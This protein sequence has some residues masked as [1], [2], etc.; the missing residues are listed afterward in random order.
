MKNKIKNIKYG[1]L[2]IVVSLMVSCNEN[3]FLKEV[4]S[5][6]YSPE[7]SYVNMINFESSLTDLYAKVR[8][9][10]YSGDEYLNTYNLLGTDII[11][12]ARGTDD[13]L[14]NYATGVIPTNWT[15]FQF[16][17]DWYKIIS[18]A[19]TMLARLD[20]SKLTDVQKVKVE[21]EAKF[22]RGFAYR[23]L[24]YLYGGVPLILEE[25]AVPKADFTRASKTDVLNQ[26]VSDLT[27]AASGLPTID[28]V[29]DGKVSNVVASHYLAETLIALGRYDEAIA[30]A[31]VTINDGNTALMTTRFGSRA[32]QNPYDALLKFTK[33]GDPFWDLFQVGNQNRKSG[34]KEA[35]W[36]IQM[37]VDIPGGLIESTTSGPNRWER[38]CNPAGWLTMNDP[39]GKQGMT[40]KPYSD[41]N[42]GGRGISFIK[43]TDFFLKD[44]WVSDFNNDI[45]NAPHNIVRDLVYN[46][47]ASAY[48]GKSAVLPNGTLNSSTWTN[49]KW[50]WYPYP[51]KNTTPGQHPDAVYENKELGTLKASASSTYRD[52]YMLR[53]AETYLLRAE[54]YLAKGD[55]GNAA[56]DINVVRARAKANP[57]ADVNVTI[58]YIL[59]ERA[60]ELVYEEQRRL[61][62][63]RT[64]KLVERVRLHNPQNA[65][66]IKDFNALFPIPSA[67][68]EANKDV[69]LEQNPGY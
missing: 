57:I 63:S 59:D 41:Y 39:A 60:R 17:R 10:H 21:A 52:M 15:I 34:N 53:L 66:N 51:S 35:L 22:F 62:L 44:L 3:D 58:D 33:P 5:D 69:V 27:A 56:I 67:E 65:G 61:T 31:S 25:V 19:N 68:I 38:N 50:R 49:Q 7:N 14:G 47:P 32:T 18:N 40:T 16:W 9:I 1:L 43:C 23:N 4:P 28:K 2:I 8:A 48:Y 55:K 45:R 26:V 20:A 42:G 36:V 24:V 13:R 11:V 12:C 46:N 6:F 37:E 30:A 54:A 64:G 29:A